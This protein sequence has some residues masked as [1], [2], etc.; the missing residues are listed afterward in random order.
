MNDSN[1]LKCESMKISQVS[2]L[3]AFSLICHSSWHD[4]LHYSLNV[5]PT[6]GIIWGLVTSSEVIPHVCFSVVKTA[7]LICQVSDYFLAHQQWVTDFCA[8]FRSV[9]CSKPLTVALNVTSRAAVTIYSSATSHHTRRNP[10]A[11]PKLGEKPHWISALELLVYF[12]ILFTF[13]SWIFC[14]S[15]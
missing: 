8:S 15:V 4:M 13:T 2:V 12:K 6:L 11:E 9:S 7:A 5:C 10:L 14:Y 3:T 1:I